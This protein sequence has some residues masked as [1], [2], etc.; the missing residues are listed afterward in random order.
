MERFHEGSRKVD[1][2]IRRLLEEYEEQREKLD[3]KIRA[4]LIR[5]LEALAITGAAIEPKVEE[6]R[7]W[8]DG[9]AHLA[10]QFEGQLNLLRDELNHLSPKRR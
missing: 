1:D 6:S 7:E 8:Q 4:D 3:R 2:R 10:P 5:K 9:Q